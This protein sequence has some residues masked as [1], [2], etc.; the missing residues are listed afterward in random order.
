MPGM[1]GMGPAPAALA[2]QSPYIKCVLVLSCSMVGY[3][4]LLLE[5]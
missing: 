1:R 2:A 5:Q 3:L 4:L